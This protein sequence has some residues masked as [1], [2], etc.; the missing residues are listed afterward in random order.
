MRVRSVTVGHDVLEAVVVFEP[1]EPLRTSEVPGVPGAVLALLPGL[2]G[3]RCDNGTGATFAE[4]LADTELAHLV[5]HAALEIAALAGSPDTLHGRT[6][7]DFAADGP[8]VFRVTL[9]Y[10][11]DLVALGA[12]DL[13]AK[14][15]RAVCCGGEAPDVEAEVRRLRGL[16]KR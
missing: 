15:V 14:V 6:S 1:G 8:G 10:D 12:L 9:E 11:D 2:R 3:H 5:E 7:W 16:R 13:A 4:E